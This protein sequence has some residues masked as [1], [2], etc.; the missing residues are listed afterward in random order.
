M[1]YHRIK[2]DLESLVQNTK[3]VILDADA[4]AAD[5]TITVKSITGIA[6]N[7]LL[8]FREL[9]NELA[10][11]VAVH[12]STVPSGNTITLAANLV[13]AHPA[14]TVVSV[15]PYN[16]LQFFHSATEDDANSDDSGLSSLASAAN[17]DPTTE[18]NYYDDSTQS[19]GYYFFR[20]SNSITSI[21]GPYSDAIPWT[22]TGTKFDRNQVGFILD[23]VLKKIGHDYDEKFSRE[24]AMDEINSCLSF[25]QGKLKHWARYLVS[26]YVLGQTSRGVFEFT[27]PSDIYDNKT[28]KSILSVKIGTA[29]GP[30]IWKDEKE[31]DDIMGQAV[32]TTV[33]TQPNVGDTTLN[34]G[35][36]YDLDDSGTV[37]IFSGNTSYEI[38]YTG[39]TRSGTAGV[40]TGIPAS[41]TGSIT[42]TFAVGL[43]VWQQ[44]EEGQP[45]YFT[46]RNGK[47]VFWPLC[48][49][50]WINKNVLLDYNT[51]ATVVDSEGDTIDADRYD[52]VK[53]WLLWQARN[54]W[55]ND[56]KEDL[57]DGDYILFREILNDQ[58]RK[59]VPNQKYKMKP[60]I[61]SIQYGSRTQSSRQVGKFENT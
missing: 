25:Q 33:R 61:N 60:K 20:F 27:M 6:V 47:I 7:D 29:L 15:I 38:T 35:N 42:V 32:R 34:I 44:Q 24:D 30:L 46:V 1:S 31:F 21:N 40:L 12:A 17:I 49:S 10:E 8:L 26:D 43:N 13:E 3:Q 37:T 11:I 58:I 4:A 5:G 53:H 18:Q 52:M 57:S 2:A 59:A 45:I 14:G 41:G 16:Q 19:S 48:D 39:V 9:G 54:Y 23:H 51:Q 36:S 22:A 56:G 50:T 55:F 28:N